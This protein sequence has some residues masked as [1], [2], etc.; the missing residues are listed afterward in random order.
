MAR[1]Q[2]AVKAKITLPADT[3]YRSPMG[4]Q[5]TAIATVRN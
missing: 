2:I 1:G 3:I 4:S 5:P